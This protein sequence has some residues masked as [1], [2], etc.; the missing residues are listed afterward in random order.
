M[1]RTPLAC[2][3]HGAVLGHAAG[4]DRYL[5]RHPVQV[6]NF[7]TTLSHAAPRSLPKTRSSRTTSGPDRPPRPHRTRDVRPTTAGP[8][9]LKLTMGELMR[10]RG[11]IEKQM[12]VAEAEWMAASEALEAVV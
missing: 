12:E 6:V 10:K 3:D 2:P 11:D 8:E 9:E 7:K 1:A 4:A 5:I